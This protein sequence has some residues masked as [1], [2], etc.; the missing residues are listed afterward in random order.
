MKSS[1]IKWQSAGAYFTAII[2]NKKHTIKPETSEARELIKKEIEKYNIDL[3]ETRLKKIIKLLS[4]KEEANKTALVVKKKV[5]HKAK[6]EAKKEI[7]EANKE[8][9]SGIDS[10]LDEESEKILRTSKLFTIKGGNAYL[11][12]FTQVRLPKTLV[13]RFVDFIKA[14]TSLEPLINFW[15]L[16]LLNPNEIARTKLF[17]YLANQNITVTP[18][19]YIVTY[20]MVKTTNRKTA[21]GKPIFTSAHTKKEDYIMG[22]AFSIPRGD[23][24]EDGSRDCSKGLHTGTHRFI[25]IVADKKS[26]S[27]LEGKEGVGDGYG[28]GTRI[29]TK[30]ETSDS[31]GTGYD[32]PRTTTSEQKF[33]N[34]FGN[35]AVICLVNPMHVVSVPHSNT[36]KMRSC[37]LYFCGTTTPEEVI[38]LVEKDYHIFD[39]QY[40]QYELSVIDKML[41]DSKF[42]E[43]IDNEKVAKGIKRKQVA[44]SKLAEV[45]QQLFINDDTVNINKLSIADVHQIIKSRTVKVK[46]LK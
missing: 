30:T 7:Q 18:R 36:R 20:R 3:K 17:D 14:D 31:Y 33:D 1:K 2:S 25:G 46:L 8:I 13:D 6:K 9:A 44:E 24:D 27:N 38:D 41:K 32:R 45:A 12:P 4:P 26:I 42:K 10:N 29:T 35:Q 5:L 43:F 16:A 34:C 23:C 28:T 19:G 37:E 22:E 21:E 15:K 40:Y 11:T 39:H